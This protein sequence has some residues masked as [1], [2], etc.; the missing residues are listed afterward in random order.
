MT[1]I[2]I[3]EGTSGPRGRRWYAVHLQPNADRIARANL[4]RQGFES[5]FP[6]RVK[7]VRHARQFRTRLAPLFPGYCFV[8]LDLSRDRWRSVNG[9]TG[10]VSLVTAGAEPLPV[11]ERLMDALRAASSADGVVDLAEGLHEGQRVRI[12]AGPFADML[13]TLEAL[14]DQQRVRILLEMMGSY[15]RVVSNARQLAPA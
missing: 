3:G 14:D 7:T 5:F 12:L 6:V 9:T 15:V 4:D 1:G 8:A 11:P 13:G 10:V 2:E